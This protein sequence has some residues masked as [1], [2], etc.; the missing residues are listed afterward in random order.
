MASFVVFIQDLEC[1][2]LFKNYFSIKCDS[3][4]DSESYKRRGRVFIIPDENSFEKPNCNKSFAKRIEESGNFTYISP[5]SAVVL[6]TVHPKLPE[7]IHPL[8]HADKSQ[9]NLRSKFLKKFTNT[10]RNLRNLFFKIDTIQNESGID[11]N[12]L[13]PTSNTSSPFYLDKYSFFSKNKTSTTCNLPNN[14]N[15]N[16]VSSL[17]NALGIFYRQ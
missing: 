11:R 7:N 12:L 5:Q 1:F 6:S 15:N 2:S 9:V 3:D 10:S 13:T 14:N 16:R 17:K 8:K 4:S